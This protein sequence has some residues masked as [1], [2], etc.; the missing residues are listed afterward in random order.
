MDKKILKKILNF[1]KERNWKQ[2]HL[3]KNLAISLSLE[4]SEV[5]ELFQ[6]TKDNH[7]PKEERDQLK[8]E[9]A[10]TYYWLILLAYE[11]S[12]DLDKVLEQKMIENAKK[13]PIKLS[14]G[15]ST[16]Y[17]KLKNE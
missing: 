12:I 14:K 2:F 8:K 4:A 15:K 16:K 6:W 9:L 1:R 3:P 13:Y 5:L 10:D 7:L 11:F 17:N